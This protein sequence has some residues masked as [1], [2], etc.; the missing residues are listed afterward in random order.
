M[1][2]EFRVKNFRGFND[3][4]VF[5]LDSVRD[6][7]F[8]KDLIKNNLVNK[9]VIFGENSSG[10]SNL[11]YAIMDISDHLFDGIKFPRFANYL[12][13]DSTEQYAT[14]TYIFQ[15]GEKTIWYLYKKD[16]N[17]RVLYEEIKENDNLLFQFNFENNKYTNNIK[18]VPDS[19]FVIEKPIIERNFSILSYIN[20]YSPNLKD[21]SAIKLVVNFAR[22]MLWFRSVRNF[23]YI[24]GEIA[25]ENIDDYIIRNDLIHELEVFFKEC[26]LEYNLIVRRNINKPILCVKY[27]NGVAPLTDVASTGTMSLWLF[28]YWMHKIENLSFLFIDEYDAF[29]HYDLSLS[30]LKKLNSNNSFQSILTT[31]NSFLAGNDIM[32]PDCYFIIKDNKIKSFADSTNRVIRQAHNLEKMMLSNEFNG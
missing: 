11:G 5:K 2:K 21:D 15:F 24:N 28:F 14:F 25:V 30:I 29:Y 17:S 13:N 10:K 4:F 31:H 26:G 32:R 19:V 16:K 27:A 23:E 12:N 18:E 1:L 22:N 8:N 3:E 6:Y 9:A 20:K 7:E